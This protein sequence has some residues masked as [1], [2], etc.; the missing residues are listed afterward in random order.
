MYHNDTGNPGMATGGAGDVLTGLIAAL[1]GQGFPVWP[2]TCLA[3]HL[4]GAAGDVARQAVGE[5]SLMATDLVKY[6]P[7][8]IRCYCEKDP[9][10]PC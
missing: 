3:V 7:P 10:N 8:A 5:V 6:L 1:I 4:H 9:A 2:A